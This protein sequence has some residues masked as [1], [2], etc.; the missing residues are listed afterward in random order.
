MRRVN[1]AF[2]KGPVRSDLVRGF[3]GPP[4]SAYCAERADCCYPARQADFRVTGQKMEKR[5]TGCMET[6]K[7]RIR[8]SMMAEGSTDL[9]TGPMETPK[10]RFSH[11]FLFYTQRR[12]RPT[13]RRAPFR[14]RTGTKEALLR[15]FSYLCRYTGGRAE[16]CRPSV[17]MH[18]LQ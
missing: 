9:P 11:K 4:E 14:E 16:A 6:V 17:R 12:R 2:C 18:C 15:R 7:K 5:R 10:Q 8:A 3:R 1:H 13:H